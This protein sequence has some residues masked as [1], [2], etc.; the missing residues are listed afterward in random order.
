M[1]LDVTSTIEVPL[2]VIFKREITHNVQLVPAHTARPPRPP[3]RHKPPRNMNG[4]FLYIRFSDL[5]PEYD[6]N[7]VQT[8]LMRCPECLRQSFTSLQGL[9][10]HA[11]ISHSKEWG[12]HDECVRAC[13]AVKPDLDVEMGTEVGSGPNGILPGIGSLFEMA[14][15]VHQASELMAGGDVEPAVAGSHVESHSQ[16]SNLNKT[17]GLHEDTPALAPFLGKEA[18]RGN[19]K[20]WVNEDDLA[21]VEGLD[22][23]GKCLNGVHTSSVTEVVLRR[24]WKMHFTHRNDFEPE[25]EEGAT[26]KSTTNTKPD[27]TISRE[28]SLFNA[29]EAN[30]PEAT[31]SRAEGL[32]NSL[33][34]TTG[35][36]FTFKLAFLSWI[37]VFGCHQVCLLFSILIRFVFNQFLEKR[38]MSSHGRPYKWMISVECAFLCRPET[39]EY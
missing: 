24:P 20:I 12:T 36:S 27:L 31:G 34:G 25:T 37:A 13:A 4:K 38:K 8:Y 32:Q 10:N 11:R 21:D 33:M 28:G 6:D 5:H 3:P 18:V 16:S 1:A 30:K 22:D 14:V 29:T 2:N 19:I 15:G 26:Q 39:P 9:L 23:D 7:H 17:L 35:S